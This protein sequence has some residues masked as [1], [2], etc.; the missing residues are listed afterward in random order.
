MIVHGNIRSARVE[1]HPQLTN[2]ITV[3]VSMN[4]TDTLKGTPRKSIEFRQYI[5]DIR[6]QIDAARYVKGEEVLL[7]LGPVSEYGLTS[8]VGLEQ[9]RFRITK[10]RNGKA[11]ALNG[12]GNLGLFQSVE[13]RAQQKGITLSKGVKAMI[14]QRQPGPVP[15]A[16]LKD[17]I[18]TLGRAE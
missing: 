9:G 14:G 16:D 11:V 15:L 3:V 5:W 2:L 10:D 8:P 17:A 7:L 6:D 4:V 12:T 18:R 1:R 13:Y